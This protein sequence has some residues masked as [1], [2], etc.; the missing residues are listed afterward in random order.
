MEKLQ[1]KQRKKI[2]E[3]WI[4]KNGAASFDLKNRDIILWDGG[5]FCIDKETKI[6]NK[7]RMVIQ[8]ESS[9]VSNGK[10]FK[11]KEIKFIPIKKN[12]RFVKEKVDYYKAVFWF[13]ELD[14]TI[15][16]LKSMKKMLNKL[17]YET[18]KSQAWKNNLRSKK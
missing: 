18:G 16:Y 6:K 5:L 7:T 17:G 2:I 4:N 13:E 8:K 10:V 1:Y 12:G 11:G 9:L 14:E 3:K 15:N